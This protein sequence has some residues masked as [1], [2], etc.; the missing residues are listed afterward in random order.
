[1]VER[2]QQRKS[3]NIFTGETA[4]NL[5]V[6]CYVKKSAVPH[7]L[8]V[9]CERLSLLYDRGSLNAISIYCTDKLDHNS[10]I[11]VL[12]FRVWGYPN[13][14]E[15]IPFPTCCYYFFRVQTGF[16]LAQEV[17]YSCQGKDTSLPSIH[18]LIGGMYSKLF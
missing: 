8:F 9:I 6:I 5:L 7:E 3:V 12:L 16:Q 10:D 15:S 11:A 18:H 2:F 17:H 4:E 13:N 14:P 1:M